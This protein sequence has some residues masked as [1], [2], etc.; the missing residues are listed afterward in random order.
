MFEKVLLATDLSPAY[1]KLTQCIVELKEI[2]T[3]EIVLVWVVDVEKASL[4]AGD[5]RDQHLKKLEVRGKE[6]EKTGLSVTYE[7]PIGLPSQEIG[8]AAHEKGLDLIVMGSRG[9]RKMRDMLIG[10]TTANVIRLSRKPILVERIDLGDK[11][12]SESYMLVCKRKFK[13]I[14]LATDF[15]ENAREAES[16]ALELASKAEKM[17]IVSVAETRG[18]SDGSSPALAKDK[19]KLDKLKQSF[20]E[21]CDHVV[22]R[23]EEGIASDNINRIADEEDITLIVIGKK[24]KGGIKEL[25]LGSTAESVA[26]RSNKPVL[27]VPSR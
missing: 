7:A 3:K 14:L 13:S 27:L 11:L 20:S 22:V 26:R 18:D 21:R 10:S 23:L 4:S 12:D 25:L 19:I 16:V 9:E 8:R 15:S 2:G 1:D 24:G 17:V 6:L 5:V